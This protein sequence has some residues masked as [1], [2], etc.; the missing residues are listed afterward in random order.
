MMRNARRM[1]L[2]HQLTNVILAVAC[3]VT[4]WG[5]VTGAG[6]NIVSSAIICVSTFTTTAFQWK[7]SR[8]DQLLGRLDEQEYVLISVL[9]AQARGMTLREWIDGYVEHSVVDRESTHH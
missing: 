1:K 4:A 9:E 2:L 3:L 5:V 6:W 8:R 7:A